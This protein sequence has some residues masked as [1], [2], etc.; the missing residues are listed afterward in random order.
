MDQQH[1]F[2][3]V[4]L[5]LP[6]S[7]RVWSSRCWGR[8]L[9]R[10]IMAHRGRSVSGR[11][12]PLGSAARSAVRHA[13]LPQPQPPRGGE[14]APR[15]TGPRPLPVCTASSAGPPA[16]RAST[17]GA[18][19]GPSRTG[20]HAPLGGETCSGTPSYTAADPPAWA[21]ESLYT[22]NIVYRRVRRGLPAKVPSGTMGLESAFKR[23]G[24]ITE[25]RPTCDRS[26]PAPLWRGSSRL[27]KDTIAT[28]DSGASAPPGSRPGGVVE[29]PMVV[30]HATIA[31]DAPPP[32]RRGH[33]RRRPGSTQHPPGRRH[34]LGAIDGRLVGE[35]RVSHG[36][37]R[38]F[39]TPLTKAR[40]V[41]HGCAGGNAPQA[42]ERCTGRRAAGYLR[43]SE[44][45]PCEGPTGANTIVPSAQPL[46]GSTSA[47]CS[48]LL[49]DY[50][51]QPRL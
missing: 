2:H 48:S 14:P 23:G 22:L 37:D 30:S 6:R 43:A 20:A 1:V 15:G 50:G 3:R 5:V 26:N 16:R 7:Q 19:F 11:A 35:D 28:L 9:C 47:L 21:A 42:R 13:P 18:C 45:S 40:M 32:A 4:G 51:V 27:L 8:A 46:M 38:S 39:R 49:G 34:G 10:A 44:G 12:D 17:E 33:R 31:A 29:L 36:G 24:P 41:R 25:T